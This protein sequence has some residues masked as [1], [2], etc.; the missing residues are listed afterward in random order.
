MGK[1]KFIPHGRMKVVKAFHL[2]INKEVKIHHT[3]K[4]RKI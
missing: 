2:Y 4:V 1:G 3:W